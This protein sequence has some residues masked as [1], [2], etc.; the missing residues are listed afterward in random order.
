MGGYTYEEE[1]HHEQANSMGYGSGRDRTRCRLQL[2]HVTRCVRRDIRPGT[3]H[4]FGTCDIFDARDVL[5]RTKLSSCVGAPWAGRRGRR[6]W[7]IQCSVRTGRRRNRGH[8]WHGVRVGLHAD[9][10]YGATGDHQ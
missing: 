10:G 6:R 4:I 5:D 9:D 3:C 1:L 8:G 7:G 2:V